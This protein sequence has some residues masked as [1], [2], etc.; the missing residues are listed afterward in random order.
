MPEILI[1][2]NTTNEIHPEVDYQEK[3]RHLND[4]EIREI[5]LKRKHYQEKAA[6]AAIEEAIRRGII[7]SEQDLFSEEYRETSGY[8]LVLFPVINKQEQKE[9]ILS[10]IHRLNFILGIIPLFFAGLNLF[11][12]KIAM[13]LVFTLTGGYWLFLNYKLLKTKK[14]VIIRDMLIILSL[15]LGYVVYWFFILKLFS[16]MDIVV[17]IIA[18][19]VSFYCL[20]FARSI[21]KR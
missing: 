2:V 11:E 14:A 19:G 10:G 16:A 18:F 1:I 6:K 4:T 7:C 13:F 20:L 12:G 9:K 17:I 15:A 8:R 5:L 21:L 3:Y